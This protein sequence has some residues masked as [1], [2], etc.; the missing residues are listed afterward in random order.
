MTDLQIIEQLNSKLRHPLRQQ[1]KLTWFL[2]GYI[3]DNLSNITHL[4]IFKSNLNGSFPEEIPLLKK[5]KHL[6]IRE[7]NITDIPD[8][9]IELKQL[10]YLDIRFNSLSSLPDRFS[11]LDCLEKLYLGHNN[12]TDIPQAI[13]KLESLW[14]LDL[15]ENK[16]NKGC[17][18]LLTAPMLTNIYLNNNKIKHFPFDKVDNYIDELVLTGN[19]LG[20]SQYPIK[21][22]I[23]KLII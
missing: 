23:N 2:K 7:N 17:E 8:N 13:G 3:V 10:N 14:L 18:I 20:H 16:I 19:T 12:F 11:Q 6:D 1:E 9:I 5:L 15:T 22:N 21:N 4:N